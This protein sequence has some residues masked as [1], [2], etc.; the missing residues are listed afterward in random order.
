MNSS[1]L[2]AVIPSGR[3]F[4]GDPGMAM[5]QGLFQ[6][7]MESAGDE[8]NARVEV[9]G[10]P[11]VLVGAPPAEYPNRGLLNQ[12]LYP[13]QSGR[14][15]LVHEDLLIKSDSLLWLGSM[16]IV[17]GLGA[18]TVV[19]GLFKVSDA[20]HANLVVI[21]TVWNRKPQAQSVIAEQEILSRAA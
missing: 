6:D 20:V 14:L 3:Y 7:A 10:R 5:R 4:L 21:D 2:A 8:R 9:E 15:G 19:D 1:D 11:V 17:T 16:I 18:V 13:C 12:C